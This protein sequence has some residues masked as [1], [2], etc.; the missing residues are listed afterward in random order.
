LG[1]EPEVEAFE[2]FLAEHIVTDADG[3]RVV[4]SESRRPFARQTQ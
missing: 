4:L 2:P 1:I 3:T